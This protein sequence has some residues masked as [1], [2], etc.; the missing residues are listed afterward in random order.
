MKVKNTELMDQRKNELMTEDI[1]NI[2]T[3]LE[4]ISKGTPAAILGTLK[5]RYKHGPKFKKIGLRNPIQLHFYQTILLLTEI[6]FKSKKTISE[7]RSDCEV[8]FGI[9]DEE[10][11][12]HKEQIEWADFIPSPF[13]LQL[14]F[15]MNRL[16]LESH[17][18]FKFSSIWDIESILEGE[19]FKFNHFK[20]QELC[21]PEYFTDE[22]KDF[23]TKLVIRTG[24]GCTTLAYI[25]V[26]E[27]KTDQAIELTRKFNGLNF[28]QG[29]EAKFRIDRGKVLERVFD[30]FRKDGDF[31]GMNSVILELENNIY[32]SDHPIS[33]DYNTSMY[34]RAIKKLVRYCLDNGRTEAAFELGTGY[35]P[36]NTYEYIG[37][38]AENKLYYEARKVTEL[39]TEQS[40][41]P[42]F[43]ADSLI[44]LNSKLALESSKTG[45]LDEAGFFFNQTLDLLDQSSKID[46]RFFEMAR[47]LSDKDQAIHI[48]KKLV[49]LRITSEEVK[50]NE[51]N[52]MAIVDIGF[53][54]GEI[55]II[56]DFLRFIIYDC[57]ISFWETIQSRLIRCHIP[58]DENLRY[59]EEYIKKL[60]ETL[61]EKLDNLNKYKDR[62]DEVDS[63]FFDTAW[64]LFR[65]RRSDQVFEMTN[66][67][68][69]RYIKRG[70]FLLFLKTWI[71]P[72]EGNLTYLEEISDE[73]NRLAKKQRKSTEIFCKECYDFIDFKINK[74]I[75]KNQVAVLLLLQ[76]A[77][78]YLE[79][80]RMG[81]FS[82]KIQKWAE[83][84]FSHRNLESEKGLGIISEF[85]YNLLTPRY[86]VDVS[87]SNRI[88]DKY[89][90][91]AAGMQ[92]LDY[93]NL[94]IDYLYK[95]ENEFQPGNETKRLMALLHFADF[96]RLLG[97]STETSR[98]IISI[99]ADIELWKKFWIEPGPYFYERD[100][101]INKLMDLILAV[102]EKNIYLNYFR[103]FYINSF[104]DF[105][106]EK[107]DLVYAKELLRFGEE[108][109]KTLYEFLEMAESCL[110]IN[111][112]Y[113]TGLFNLS[114]I[115]K[116]RFNEKKGKIVT[117][118]SE[119]L[120][121][122]VD[123]K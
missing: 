32:S 51:E 13:M 78:D 30:R 71:F 52:L 109:Q 85:F 10:F 27:G 64:L 116:D 36:E 26:S 75:D 81:L 62:I 47:Y 70:A 22:E 79:L 118:M 104:K 12:P 99:T 55:E 122:G 7:K 33:E 98:L 16:G 50:G 95:L 17:R 11:E 41:F 73:I 96:Y 90:L 3:L 107:N 108:G 101:I 80:L 66:K 72:K 18:L 111:Y 21:F 82:E 76:E 121:E 2:N 24:V 84:F 92:Q 58:A 100:R 23:F 103:E 91:L 65:E 44:M 102:N 93:K 1:Q 45:C 115:C 46:G 40:E 9:L 120:L 94:L 69:V 114:L 38:L 112:M 89:V 59:S 68:V 37:I 110:R 8:I 29:P 56:K 42:W 14:A 117:Y 86:Y 39:V 119:R 63:E 53:G 31:N 60:E 28:D 123:L 106:L 15:E 20:E 61:E 83:E 88:F 49:D 97:K 4:L 105:M 74:Q 113:K 43:Y 87:N 35:G 77:G 67:L 34:F 25:L 5:K 54:T 19:N 48:I 57:H 6:C